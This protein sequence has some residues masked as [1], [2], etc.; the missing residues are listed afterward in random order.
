MTWCIPFLALRVSTR[1]HWPGQDVIID[2]EQYHVKAVETWAAPDSLVTGGDRQAL[3]PHGGT[4]KD[5]IDKQLA[6]GPQ[7][8]REVLC[9]ACGKDWH[10]QPTAL[11]NEAGR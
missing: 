7:R 1:E 3:R 4:M 6:A 8:G 9:S 10:G 11:C 2:G 5:D